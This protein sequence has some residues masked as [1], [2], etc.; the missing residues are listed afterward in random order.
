MATERA[1]AGQAA[2]DGD[3]ACGRVRRHEPHR[4]H[5]WEL[6]AEDDS[7]RRITVD[8]PGYERPVD[9]YGKQVA[10]YE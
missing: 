2:P 4:A 5:R 10:R 3:L 8:C 6:Q 1:R 9:A 7:P